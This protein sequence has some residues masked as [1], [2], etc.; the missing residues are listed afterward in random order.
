MPIDLPPII[1]PQAANA[2]QVE[3]IRRAGAESVYE[4]V[5]AGYTLRISGNRYL[6]REQL[7]LLTSSAKTPA[8]A[9]NAL[10]QAYYQL[11]HLLTTVYYSQQDKMVYVHVVHGHLADIKAPEEIRH[12]FEDLIGDQ[13]LRRSEFDA[14]R[15]LANLDSERRGVGYRVSYQL[16]P[17][18]QAYTLVFKEEPVSDHDATEIS[19]NANNYGNRFLGR[20]FAGVSLRHDFDNAIQVNF[21]YDRA[22]SEFGETNGGDYYNGYTLRANMPTS[23]GLYGLEGRYTE[24]ARTVDG[25]QLGDATTAQACSAADLFCNLASPPALPG[26]QDVV[27]PSAPTYVESKTS[28]LAAT[29][30][31]VLLSDTLYRL[32]LSERLEVV[33][34]TITAEGRGDVLDEPQATLELGVKYNHLTRVAGIASKF[35]LHNFVD[36]GLKSDGGT[37]DTDDREDTVAPGRRSGRFVVV[38]PRLSWQLGLVDWASLTASVSGQWSDGRQLPLQQQYFLGGNNGLSAYLPGILVG[39]SGAYSRLQFEANGLPLW[40]FEFKPGVFI[41]HGQVWYED[42]EG[43]QGDTRSVADAGISLKADYKKVLQTEFIAARPV[44]DNN[45]D[46][47]T[48]R[49][50]EVDFFWRFKLGF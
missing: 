18:R 22:L 1:P 50:A 42:V 15:V 49:R 25:A 31:Q 6:S 2:A 45:V 14:P 8:Q 9:V 35:T 13:D 38:K 5:I 44:A 24:Y 17:D 21:S 30:E 34:S 19:L 47:E 41:E 36:V 32:T 43:P 7:D 28:S 23:W 26:S 40:G 27:D 48:L 37:F 11:G 12:Y 3:Q 33:E 29:G 10:N 4:V 46:K 20:Y 16:A 39:D